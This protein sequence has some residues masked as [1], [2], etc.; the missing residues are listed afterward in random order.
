MKYSAWEK[1]QGNKRRNRNENYK[2]WKGQGKKQSLNMVLF[3]V[4]LKRIT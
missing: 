1:Q 3:N 2:Y 4:F